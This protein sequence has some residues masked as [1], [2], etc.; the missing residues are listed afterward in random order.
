M[1]LRN[2][3]RFSIDPL[4][5]E[6]FIGDVGTDLYEELDLATGGENFGYPRYEGPGFFRENEQ[7]LLPDPTF[8]AYTY[9]QTTTGRAALPLDV[10]RPKAYP[11]DL[12]FPEAFHGVYFFADF[13]D[14]TLQ[15]LL[16]DD[17][18][19]ISQHAFGEDYSQLGD[20]AVDGDGG[21]Y[22]LS[23]RGYLLKIDYNP[24]AVVANEVA[25]RPARF[26]LHQNYPNPFQGSSTISYVLERAE[27]VKI[28][29]FDILGRRVALLQDAWQTP[30]P[31]VQVF[32][33]DHLPGGL[34]LLQL[35]AGLA[36]EAMTM[37]VLGK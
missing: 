22:L 37:T 28:E 34:Y 12:S 3:F 16:K 10:Y 9:R 33:A 7:L 6:L 19:S 11:A 2:P 5:D 23:Y 25:K 35:H 24:D 36:R 26:T 30:G 29:V 27:H 8:P 20:G 14:D 15:Y 1:G 4:T 18:G 21:L 31:H 13:F 17:A 32:E